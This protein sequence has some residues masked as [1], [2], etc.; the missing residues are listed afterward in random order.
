MTKILACG[1]RKLKD[2]EL[3][4]FFLQELSNDCTV[5]HGA[6]LCADTIAG[7]V[8]KALG[9]TVRSYAARWLQFG[10]GAGNIRNQAMLDAEHVWVQPIDAC[11]YF[12]GDL[13]LVECDGTSDMVSRCAMAGIKTFAG[14]RDKFDEWREFAQKERE[15]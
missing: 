10:L 9:M 2:V 4:A 5:I 11:L 12:T 14:T 7:E 13:K 1:S 6:A 15:T 8:A 3:V